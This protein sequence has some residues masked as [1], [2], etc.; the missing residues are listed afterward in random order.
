V[1]RDN[2]PTFLTSCVVLIV[3]ACIVH[4]LLCTEEDVHKSQI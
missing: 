4:S 2:S 3:A 1:L